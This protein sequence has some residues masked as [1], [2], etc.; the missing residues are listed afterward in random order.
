MSWGNMTRLE[1]LQ[2]VEREIGKAERD[3]ARLKQ[4]HTQLLSA[5]ENRPELQLAGSIL[6][7]QS[8]GGM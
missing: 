2:Q 8:S 4:E 3:L 6:N 5:Y 7:N 1:K